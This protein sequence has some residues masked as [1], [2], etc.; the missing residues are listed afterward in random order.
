MLQTRL[1]SRHTSIPFSASLSDAAFAKT[2]WSAASMGQGLR[3]RLN[4]KIFLN[5]YHE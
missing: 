1:F 3:K 2:I 5:P 4:L